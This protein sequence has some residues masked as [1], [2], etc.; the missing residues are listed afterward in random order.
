[1]SQN[2]IAVVV[3]APCRRHETSITPHET[4]EE[5][6]V[7]GGGCARGGLRARGTLL[8]ILQKITFVDGDAI[9]LKERTILFCESDTFMVFFLPH[10]IA[11]DRILLI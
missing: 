7:W 9:F 4:N 10:N 5:S 8:I 3:C 2:T 1:M 11:D 6:A